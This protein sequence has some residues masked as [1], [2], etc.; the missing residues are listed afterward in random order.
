LGGL[1]EIKKSVKSCRKSSSGQDVQLREDEEGG[2]DT[3]EYAAA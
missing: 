2:G 3:E 1:K